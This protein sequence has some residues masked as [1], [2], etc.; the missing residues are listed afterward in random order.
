MGENVSKIVFFSI[1][2]HGHINPTLEVVRELV[3]RGNEVYYYLCGGEEEIFR[4]KIEES[5]AKFITCKDY[6]VD[7]KITRTH[8]ESSSKDLD[9]FINFLV[10]ATLDIGEFIFTHMKI[11]N[12]DCIVCDNLTIWGKLIALKLNIPF[13]SSNTTFVFNEYSVRILKCNIKDLIS[14][15]TSIPKAN[16]NLKRLREK[17]YPIKNILD[18][19]KNKNSTHT[20]VYTSSEFQPFSHTFSD[21][22][23]FVGPTIPEAKSRIEKTKDKLVYISMGT[24]NNELSSFYK[25][26]IEAFKDSEYQVII[27]VGNSVD[28]DEFENNYENISIF[29][30]VDQV[31]VLKEADVFISHS[32]MNSVSESLYNKVP[33]VMF[34]QTIEQRGVAERVKQLG[35]G[36]ILYG[37]TPKNI[38]DAVDKV[39]KNKN[40]YK[41]AEI[42]SEGFKKCTGA[43]GAANKILE[44]CR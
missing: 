15:I 33:L 28:L 11:L 41:R 29:K 38:R 2:A 4:N 8:L 13:V 37:I 42:I 1:P 24:V 17:G 3:S 32:G 44:M 6:N 26:C 30:K 36:K 31:A 35:A 14:V 27:S 10:D 9:F 18:V 16:K 22:Y 7:F 39:L 34:P 25:N 12:P 21:K 43:K 20:I 5:G 19:M 23:S 40:F